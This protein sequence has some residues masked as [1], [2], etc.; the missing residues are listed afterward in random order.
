ML[1]RS[2]LVACMVALTSA[3]VWAGT[4]DKS[5]SAN[6]MQMMKAE[7]AKC[8]VCKNM[9]SHLDEIGPSLK[10]EAA[11]LNNGVAIMHSVGDPTKV[12]VFHQASAA[13]AKAGQTCATMSDEDAKTQLCSFCQS[14]RTTMK[15]GAKMSMGETKSGDIMVLTSD[16]PAVQ[17]QIADIGAKCA[18]MAGDVQAAR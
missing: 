12:A 4:T 8:A 13:C 6:Q 7:M 9:V 14:M 15:A 5:M 11:K 10:M 18:M 16:D 1:K 3:A 2:L 17:A